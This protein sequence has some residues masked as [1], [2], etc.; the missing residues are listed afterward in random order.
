MI[1]PAD[2]VYRGTD[3]LQQ[4]LAET[5]GIFVLRNVEGGGKVSSFFYNIFAKLWN[6]GI[7][8][9][10]SNATITYPHYE[11]WAT[12]ISLGGSLVTIAVHVAVA[13]K[14][15]KPQKINQELGIKNLLKYMIE[16]L[17]FFPYSYRV[18]HAQDIVPHLPPKNFLGY[19]Q[20]RYEV[21]YNNAMKEKDPYSICYSGEDYR[22]SNSR[23]LNY[24]TEDHFTYFNTFVFKF[25]DDG[26]EY[27]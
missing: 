2:A 24:G 18:T 7:R 17:S 25:I 26:C 8:S 22:C 9:A 19:Y 16:Q 21:W 15:F 1:E 5:L 6:D 12:G 3:S 23:W 13:E 10:L 11:L 4:L 27:T 14:M 20:H